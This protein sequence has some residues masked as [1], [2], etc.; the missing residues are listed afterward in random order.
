M[1]KTTT[2]KNPEKPAAQ[3]PLLMPCDTATWL[4]YV[5]EFEASKRSKI[6]ER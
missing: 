3:F 6:E 4:D 5:T 1:D 2:P